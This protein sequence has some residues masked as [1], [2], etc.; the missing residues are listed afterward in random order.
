MQR[1]QEEMKSLRTMSR[2]PEVIYYYNYVRKV[3]AFTGKF[4]SVKRTTDLLVGCRSLQA[5]LAVQSKYVEIWTQLDLNLRLL[6]IPMRPGLR[7]L[8]VLNHATSK[9]L[10]T[11]TQMIALL[12][13]LQSDFYFVYFYF[14]YSLLSRERLSKR[15]IIWQ[16]SLLFVLI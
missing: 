12:A 5:I 1:D 10:H 2:T 8:C 14:R 3:L 11:F 7:V 13:F 6:A 16:E 4:S 15:T 9:F